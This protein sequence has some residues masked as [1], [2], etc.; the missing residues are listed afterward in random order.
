MDTAELLARHADVQ[1]LLEAINALPPKR[2]GL[3]IEMLQDGMAG[4]SAEGFRV[5]ARSRKELRRFTNPK[6]PH[7]LEWMREFETGEVFYDIG[8]NVGGLTLAA[9]A[10]HRDRIRIV[11]FEPSFGSFESLARNLSLNSLLSSVIPLQV[12]LLDRT[13]LEPMNYRSM[14]AGTSLHGVGE[15]IDHMGQPF[16]PVAV[17]MV[18]TFT[19]DDLIDVLKLP[20][21]T[22][23]KI[24]VDGYEGPV[25]RGATRT[26]KADTVRDLVVEVVNH[27]GAGTRLKEVSALLGSCEYEMIATLQHS[28]PED[29]DRSLVADYLFRRNAS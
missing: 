21:P 2:R 26:L 3:V 29:Q 12:A 24:D 1:Q 22:R 28:A 10:M 16:A 6:D 5:T 18:P 8:A 23:I 27:D 17:Q 15:A 19:L 14:A 9:A 13:G 25:L 20:P 11:A 7:I 4:E